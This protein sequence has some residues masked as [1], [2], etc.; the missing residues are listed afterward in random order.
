[1]KK[2]KVC[3]WCSYS[4]YPQEGSFRLNTGAWHKWVCNQCFSN[5][6]TTTLN[7]PLYCE[8]CLSALSLPEI[9]VGPTYILCSKCEMVKRGVKPINRRVVIFESFLKLYL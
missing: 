1:M 6:V 4:K 2:S 5:A 3:E 7:K 8:C 9:V